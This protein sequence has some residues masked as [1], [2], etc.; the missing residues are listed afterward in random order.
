[1]VDLAALASLASLAVTG[2][3]LA[4][5][6]G[7]L[8]FRGG[9]WRADQR[10]PDRPPNHLPGRPPD[11]PEWPGVVI[12]IPARNEAPTIGRAV[13]SLLDQDYPGRVSVVVVDDNSD[14]GTFYAAGAGQAATQ[15]TETS[16]RLTVISG[17]PLAPGWSG[18]LWAVKQGL[19]AARDIDGD[20][21]YVLLTD[22]DILHDRQSLL[23]LVAKAEGDNLDLVSLMV[24]LRA[25][26]FWERLLIP[27]FVFFFQKLFPFPWVND[28]SRGTAAAAGGCLLV[29]RPALEKMG[30]VD[31]IRGRLIDDCALAE[32]IKKNGP[33][34]LGLTAKV[35]SLRSYD[36][37]GEIWRMVTR[38]AYEQL[39]NSPLLLAGAVLGM[40]VLY[41]VPPLAAFLGGDPW[42]V[43]AAVVTWWGL[44]EMA[45]GPT[46]RL[47]GMPLVWGLLLPV[48][49]FLFT[50]M[51]VASAIRHWQG[52][53]RGW[54]GRTYGPGTVPN[55]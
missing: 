54:K 27:A 49:A 55:R 15:G 30:G 52:R 42:I 46:L 9:F 21:P 40:T 50:L 51:T 19:V 20:A 41:L 3:S 17:E 24:R 18:K 53:G 43:G 31:A 7:L 33:I 16:G 4:L 26:T 38:T 47:Y 10:L 14:D 2:L 39:G 12:V 35:E 11:Q 37:L 34:W 45:Y 48:S 29:R 28:P 32:A 36:G 44:M 8:A 1:M 13:A 23:R 25:E 6:V 22:A 5:W